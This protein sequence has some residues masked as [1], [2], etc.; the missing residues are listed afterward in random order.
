MDAEHG[1]FCAR[2]IFGQMIYVDRKADF[3]ARQL[4]TWPDYLIPAFTADALA[5]PCAIRDV[6]R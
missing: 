3:V 6:C 5:K 1:D 2:G 4:S